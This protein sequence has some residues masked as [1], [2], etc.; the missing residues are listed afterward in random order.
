[1]A[2][3]PNASDFPLFQELQCASAIE[4]QKCIWHLTGEKRRCKNHLNEVDRDEAFRQRTAILRSL[5]HEVSMEQL[6]EYAYLKCCKGSHRMSITKNDLIEQLARKWQQELSLRPSSNDPDISPN[7]PVIAGSNTA[8][9]PELFSRTPS[10]TIQTRLRSYQESQVETTST[11]SDPIGSPPPAFRPRKTSKPQSVSSKLITPLTPA[12]ETGSIYLYTR[13]SS[14][15][16]VKI[17]YSVDVHDRLKRW[18]TCGYEPVLLAAFHNIPH[19]KKT[20]SLVHHQLAEFWRTEQR[21]KFCRSEHREWFEIDKKDAVRVAGQWAEWMKKAQPYNIQGFLK[22]VWVDELERLN[23]SGI[24]VTAEALLSAHSRLLELQS[25]TAES[26]EENDNTVINATRSSLFAVDLTTEPEA[27][28]HQVQDLANF[29]VAMLQFM[30]DFDRSMQC[31]SQALI[32]I[33]AF[34]R[35][36]IDQAYAMVSAPARAARQDTGATMAS[37]AS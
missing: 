5:P 24:P 19:M 21:C 14:P 30:Q 8:H 1:M 7:P 13:A 9:E 11:R 23:V 20:E 6:R 26:M 4:K 37:G 35:A 12:S 32:A 33:D 18:R 31:T 2:P 28:L 27:S 22:G 34:R 16:Y 36:R 15:G 25:R 17:G 29:T 10:R 3:L